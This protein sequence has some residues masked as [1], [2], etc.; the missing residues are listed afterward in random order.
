ML[1]PQIHG[2]SCVFTVEPP[3]LSV[4][5]RRRVFNMDEKFELICMQLLEETAGQCGTFGELCA[6]MKTDERRMNN[7]FYENFG[8]SGEDVFCKFLIDSIVIAV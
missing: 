2:F 4:N 1:R 6:R 5:Q 7:L 3:A 8:V